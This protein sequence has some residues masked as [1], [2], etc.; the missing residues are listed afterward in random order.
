MCLPSAD[1]QQN[2]RVFAQQGMIPAE[3]ICGRAAENFMIGNIVCEVMLL[4]Q[5]E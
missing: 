1:Q 2:A 3:P 5:K 4:L